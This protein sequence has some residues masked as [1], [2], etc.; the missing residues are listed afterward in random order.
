[1]LPLLAL[2]ASSAVPLVLQEP[3][4]QPREFGRV[5]WG[6]ELEPALRAAARSERPVMLLFQEVPG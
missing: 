2:A 1:M 5:R 4:P 3:A 6:R